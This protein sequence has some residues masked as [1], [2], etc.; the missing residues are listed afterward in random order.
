MEKVL[1][2][3]ITILLGI[4]AISKKG[5]SNGNTHFA[6]GNI[7]DSNDYYIYHID[8]VSNT[9]IIS[10]KNGGHQYKIL[11]SKKKRVM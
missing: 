7:V 6:A 2:I 5:F 8:S 4:Y 9:Y 11:T 10:A 3:T 1:T